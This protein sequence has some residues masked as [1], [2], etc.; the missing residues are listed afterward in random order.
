MAG[1]VDKKQQQDAMMAKEAG[2]TSQIMSKNGLFYR[3]P[4]A[5]STAV[6]RTHKREFSERQSYSMGQTIVFT[7][8][9]GT[10]YVDPQLC[11]L[12]LTLGP[13]V[14]PTT[15]NFGSGLGA[16]SLIDEIRIYSKNGTEV[17]R[18][19]NVNFLAKI[20]SDY[21]CSKESL[22]S[23]QM[24]GANFTNARAAAAVTAGLEDGYTAADFYH[25]AIPMKML[26]GFFRPVVE[27]ML[28][29]AGLASGMR[30]EMTLSSDVNRV[31]LETGGVVT[32]YTVSN[33]IMLMSL[34]SMNDPTQVALVNES[35]NSGLEYT[36]PSYFAT[37]LRPGAVTIVNQQ[38]QKAVSQCTRVFA[39]S[40]DLAGV[41]VDTA[42]NNGF[43]SSATVIDP[44]TGLATA[45]FASF[46]FRVGSSYYPQQTVTD[47]SEAW[48][49]AQNAFGALR[50]IEY[51]PNTVTWARYHNA[52]VA[53]GTQDGAFLVAHSLETSDKL[54][55]S[56]LPIN[57]SS[58]LQLSLGFKDDIAREIL[59][60]M[61]YIT[62]AKVN[63]NK[64][65]IKI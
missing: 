42:T 9:T 4:Q 31:F 41:S 65:S 3:L 45:G 33:P 36:F 12:G 34:A 1:S 7:W 8:N 15:Y 43:S 22:E 37:K 23:L 13:V 63:L 20:L 64:T 38:V 10:D 60:F 50:N 28:I 24:I 39:A 46:Q 35:S 47:L 27:D 17:D 51:A 2:S 57:N 32:A 16:C 61:E 40:Y 44:T 29:P 18:I 54:N 14:G 5:L 25:F 26:S 58:V 11:M 6:N 52:S 49:V 56:G 19:Q 53:A 62:V 30:I 48:Y 55:L 59:I 21:R